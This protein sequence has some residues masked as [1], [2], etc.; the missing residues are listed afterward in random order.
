M[1][2]SSPD[3]Q[4]PSLGDEFTTAPAPFS[5][6]FRGLDPDG[7]WPTTPEE[8]MPL[9]FDSDVDGNPGITGLP[10]AGQVPGEPDGITFSDPRLTITMNPPPRA[11]QLFLALRTR[12]GLQGRLT[13]C[14]APMNGTELLGPRLDGNVV[15]NTLKVETRNV[16]CTVTGTNQACEKDQV[17][18]IDDNL[19]Q[20]NPNGT[21]RFVALKIPD[22]FTCE[23]VRSLQY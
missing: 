3:A 8:M 16:A 2:I 22:N 7:P 13:A 21:S 14:A 1:S 12:A 17:K 11:S 5:F 10:F 9:M 20:F 4:H 19:P 6:G 23:E 15:P 18:F